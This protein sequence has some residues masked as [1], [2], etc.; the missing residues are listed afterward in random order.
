MS[1]LMENAAM[2]Y[3]VFVIYPEYAWLCFL[4]RRVGEPC[5]SGRCTNIVAKRV[6][7]FIQW[8]IKFVEYSGIT[9]VVCWKFELHFCTC[10]QIFDILLLFL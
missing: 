5:L 3:I 7:E 1:L 8:N 9:N 6:G 10:M 4:D 2:Y